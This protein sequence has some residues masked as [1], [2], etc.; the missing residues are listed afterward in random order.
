MIIL[1]I[2]GLELT[3]VNKLNLQDLKQKRFGNTDINEFSLP[4]TVVLWASFLTGKNMEPKV[5]G[6]LWTFRVPPKDTFLQFFQ[7]YKVIDLPAFSYGECHREERKWLKEFFEKEDNQ[8]ILKNYNQTAWRNHE[9]QKKEFLAEINKKHNLLIGYFSLGDVISHLNF[10][11]EKVMAEAYS[12]L[13]EIARQAH[14][15]A[16]KEK[17]I[18]VSDHGMQAVGSFGDHSMTGFYSLN[19][20]SALPPKPKITDFFSL[21]KSCR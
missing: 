17:I 6:D 18:I 10:G 8:K 13:N 4:K 1:A 19:F 9:S 11:N 2:D 14:H 16:P 3:L 12:E 15:L 5:K 20:D 21:I 7:D